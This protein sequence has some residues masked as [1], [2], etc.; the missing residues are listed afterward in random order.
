MYLNLRMICGV[1]LRRCQCSKV[2]IVIVLPNSSCVFK[3]TLISFIQIGA[4]V[5]CAI[6]SSAAFTFT[7]LLRQA[8][9]ECM[10]Q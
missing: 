2:D 4:F 9:L 7:G 8:T 5:F 10:T 1:A 3:I 6:T